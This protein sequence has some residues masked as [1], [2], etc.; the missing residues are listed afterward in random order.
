ML[1]ATKNES[2]FSPKVAQ[3]VAASVLIKSDVAQNIQNSCK[4]L[5]YFRNQIYQQDILKV[6]Q[7]GHTVSGHVQ[8]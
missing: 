3:N 6:A 4:K 2:N 7:S 1:S 8:K 5:D